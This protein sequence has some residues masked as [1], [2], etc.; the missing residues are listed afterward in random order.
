[1][2]V[3]RRLLLSLPLLLPG[4]V[5]A[6]T[7]SSQAARIAAGKAAIAAANGA[8]WAEADTYAAAAEPLIAKVVLWMRLSHRTAPATAAE[9]VGFLRD[10]PDW[11]QVDTIARRAEA[12]FGGPQDDPLVLA[13]FSAFPPRSLSAALR[14]AEALTRS[15]GSQTQAGIVLDMMRR[16]PD[17]APGSV[18]RPGARPASNLQGESG[19]QQTL[20]RAWITSRPPRW[21]PPA[22]CVTP[23]ETAPR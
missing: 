6:Q 13:H 14:H 10:N 8:R 15:T 20:R 18:T 12:A 23:P 3:P 5:A 21:P 17:S 2:R 4:A 7:A 9:L 19:A 1:M 16:G 22:R 11:P